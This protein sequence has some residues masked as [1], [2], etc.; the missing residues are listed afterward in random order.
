MIKRRRKG[1]QNEGGV[2]GCWGGQ[3]C[4]W[5]LGEAG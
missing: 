3:S 2:D 1:Y 4:G 5:A